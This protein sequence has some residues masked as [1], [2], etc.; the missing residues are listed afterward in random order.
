MFTPPGAVCLE[1]L[2]ALKRLFKSAIFF[3]SKSLN[4]IQFV[5]AS[6]L[7]QFNLQHFLY[8]VDVPNFLSE[9]MRKCDD[10][11]LEW[12][13]SEMRQEMGRAATS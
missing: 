10:M 4:A 6:I 12:T 3:K 7:Q 11:L 9:R 1:A 13:V 5:T 8:N 2:D